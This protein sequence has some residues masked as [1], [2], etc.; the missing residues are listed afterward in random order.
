ME[1]GAGTRERVSNNLWPPEN[2]KGPVLL[3]LSAALT[4][5]TSSNAPSPAAQRQSNYLQAKGQSL[6]DE[7]ISAKVAAA[8]LAEGALQDAEIHVRTLDNVVELVGYVASSDDGV[9]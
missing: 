5:C 9:R 1:K 3:G 8:I 6:E 4:A 7:S 2:Q